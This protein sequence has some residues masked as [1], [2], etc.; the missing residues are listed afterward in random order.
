MKHFKK[1]Q[2]ALCILGFGLLT[3]IILKI[4]P[5]K[6]LGNFY[7]LSWRLVLVIAVTS[8]GHFFNTLGWLQFFKANK[9]PVSLWDLFKIKIA[10]EA[11]NTLTP[12]SFVG[13]D[14][15]RAIMLH[16]KEP[17]V[18]G[19]ASIVVDRTVFV[20]STVLLVIAGLMMG[21]LKLSIPLEIRLIL[22]GA[23]TALILGLFFLIRHQRGGFF[24]ST[25]GLAKKFR[26][27]KEYS[28]K[29]LEKCREFDDSIKLFYGRNKRR[30]AASI[31]FHFLGRFV[32]VFEV[33][34]LAYFLGIPMDFWTAFFLTALFPLLNFAFGII[35]GNV[36]VLEGATGVAF[37][38]LKLGLADGVTLQLCRRIR[39][40]FWI[41]VGLLIIASHGKKQE[42]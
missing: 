32:G 24:I 36:G 6:I 40:V 17:Q 31:L 1:I 18:A 13:G 42:S 4:G 27:R 26:I 35:P 29:T 21:F 5:E 3:W 30:F 38:L 37:H 22:I 9:T 41:L 2:I 14:P 8:S 12:L 23:I 10:G 16:H 11:T 15:I 20:I 7:D 34:F 19:S 25:L 28:E 39:S 33:F